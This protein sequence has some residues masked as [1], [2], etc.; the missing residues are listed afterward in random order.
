MDV[1]DYQAIA[2]I[3]KAKT[4]DHEDKNAYKMIWAD[5]L[6]EA[7]ADYMAARAICRCPHGM[8]VCPIH[9]FDRA[10]WI[11]TCDGETAHQDNAAPGPG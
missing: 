1:K 5:Q 9:N 11:A 2:S 10:A 7:L 3:I 6:V 8:E 4:F